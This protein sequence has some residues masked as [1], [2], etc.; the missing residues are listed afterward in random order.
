MLL[1]SLLNKYVDLLPGQNVNSA[2]IPQDALLVLS[3]K[4]YAS[5]AIMVAKHAR[6]ADVPVFA[7]TDSYSAPIVS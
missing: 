1:L 4:P 3:I 6:G 5:R 2:N 7:V